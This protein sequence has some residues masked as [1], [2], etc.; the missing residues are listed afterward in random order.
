MSEYV[1]PW[2]S[3]CIL[4][5]ILPTPTPILQGAHPTRKGWEASLAFPYS[6]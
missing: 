5:L 2:G 4:E 1:E 3:Q 6:D